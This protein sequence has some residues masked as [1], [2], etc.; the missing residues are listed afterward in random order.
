MGS[1]ASAENVY[2]IHNNRTDD[3]FYVDTVVFVKSGILN[4]NEGMLQILRNRI[5]S[6]ILSI[7][8]GRGKV[9]DFYTGIVI[10]GGGESLW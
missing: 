7:G 4:G 5:Q 3:T 8:A 9:F 10:D 6:N 2:H 1:F